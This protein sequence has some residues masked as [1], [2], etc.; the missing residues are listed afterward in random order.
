[1]DGLHEVIS[2]RA[3]QRHVLPFLACGE[4]HDWLKHLRHEVCTRSSPLPPSIQAGM[5]NPL[6]QAT[7]SQL[8]ASIAHLVHSNEAT[9]LATYPLSRFPLTIGRSEEADICVDDRWL[10]R[11]HCEIDCR[12]GELVIRDLGSRHGTYL[13]GLRIDE[14]PLDV[15]D[16]LRIGLSQFTISPAAVSAGV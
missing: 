12:D 4:S 11:Q 2:Y 16:E 9:G 1:V 8:T 13:N 5:M 3:C 15:D 7:R 10:S 14:S 6:S